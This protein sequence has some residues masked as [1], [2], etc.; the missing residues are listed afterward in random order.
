MKTR[1]LFLSAVFCFTAPAWAEDSSANSGEQPIEIT[2]DGYNRFV[3][4]IATAEGNVIVHYKGDIVYADRVNYDSKTKTVMA[5][6]N[7]RIFS[8]DRIYRGDHI[9]Y[10]FETK[11]VQSTDFKTAQYPVFSGG[12]LATTPEINHYRI[13]DGFFTT[14]NREHPSYRLEADTLEIY[15][16]DQVVLKN[17]LFYVG[18]VP[19]LWVPF[20]VQS[21]SDTRSNFIFDAGTNSR[22]GGF[23]LGTYNWYQTANLK[24]A[25]H[26]DVRTRRGLAGGADV[27]F[28]ANP[29]SVS[30]LKTYY[31]QDNDPNYNP[32]SLPRVPIN[33]G[34]Y[35][36]SYQ[37]HLAL[38]P[39]LISTADINYWSDPYI[40]QDFFESEFRKDRQPDNFVD[41]VQ[42]DPNYTI[43]FLFRDQINNFFETTDRLP[44]L[45]LEIKRQKIFNSPI[46]YEGETSVAELRKS[47]DRT[48]YTATFFPAEP[49]HAGMT[50]YSAYRYDTFHQFLYPKQY[51][52]WLNLT[53]R[54]GIR[55]T[56]WSDDN[57]T[58]VTFGPIAAPP[59]PPNAYNHNRLPNGQLDKNDRG[60]V[61]FDAG[62]EGSFKVSKTW[63][64]AKDDAWKIDG[65]RH[66]MEPFANLQYVPT[67][68]T[69]PSDIRGFDDRLPSTR[70]QSINFPEYNS[71]DSIDG[72][73]VIR[74]G[75]RNTIQTKRDGQNWDLA[76]WLVYADADFDR[77]TDVEQKA[78]HD[79]YSDIY[80]ELTISPVPWLTFKSFDAVDVNGDSYNE[81]DNSISWQPDRATSFTLG[82][83]YLSH[84]VLFENSN[85]IYLSWFYRLNENWQF[86]TRHWFEG[87]DGRLQEQQYTIYR[88]LTSWQLA[89][90]IMDRDNGGGKNEELAYITLTLKAFPNEKLPFKLN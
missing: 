33:D 29:E 2:A 63:L 23:F 68:D 84:S 78:T 88:D 28:K 9:N 22:W 19:V 53:P 4:G 7:V 76:N 74:H 59:P 31:A 77:H 75:I 46:E 61:V 24:G 79:T 87:A 1:V 48:G 73:A 37:Q 10:N 85:L 90:T 60:R 58:D 70:L 44:E 64:E 39:D 56:Y 38:A 3:A 36:I 41:L 21:L 16:N 18:D 45:K 14:D 54:I 51:F 13:K 86:E 89:F 52:N 15:P 27:D 30:L 20:Y 81:S 40:T 11:A 25:V 55:G 71:I 62:L 26:F 49:T 43:S 8:G 47:Y 6:G 34:R 66:V 82:N 50:S 42:Y 65:I 72:Q 5:D 80:N 57:T 17:A 35:L 67:P 83:R 69:R 32:T 12:K